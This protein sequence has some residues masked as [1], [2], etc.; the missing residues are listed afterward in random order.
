[1]DMN[2]FNI[3]SNQELPCKGKILISSPFMNDI[4]FM[5]SVILLVEHD[6]EG[7]VGLIMNKNF[8]LNLY[9]NDLMPGFENV[10]K[11]PVYKGGPVGC[12]TL[13]YIHSLENL[14]GAIPIMPGLYLN[15][16][17]EQL[18]NF[19]LNNGDIE[20]VVR[21]FTG[22]AGWNANQL[23]DEINENSWLVT[24]NQENLLSNLNLK[25]LWKN[26]LHKMGDKYALW[27]KYPIYPG[28][29]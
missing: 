15:G 14:E 18:K 9:L 29:N 2:L 26:S 11:I 17:F 10:K 24:E 5:R 12:D 7:S 16:N 28:L 13:F 19:I 6:Q 21:F 1:M 20:G 22:Y 25:Q 27:A 23:E 4:H 3:V 8:K